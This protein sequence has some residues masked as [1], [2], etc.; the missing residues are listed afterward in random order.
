MILGIALAAIAL[1]G[2]IYAADSKTIQMSLEQER[3][4]T[5]IHDVVCTDNHILMTTPSGAYACIF[6]DH[7]FALE[8]RGFVFVS[9]SF[10]VFPTGHSGQSVARSIGGGGG[11]PP[12]I[13]MSR[14][15]NI[16]ET[17]IVEIT[18][19]NTLAVNAT[20]T[21][22][23][24][25][26]PGFI[27]GWAI[28]SGFEVV[29]PADLEYEIR[30]VNATNSAAAIHT[31]FTPLNIGESIT[32]R[33]EIR[34]ISE[35]YNYVAGFGYLDSEADISLYLD[36]EETLPY[37]E[38]RTRYPEMHPVPERTPKAKNTEMFPPLT[39][40]ERD[41]AIK[42]VPPSRELL[43]DFFEAYFSSTETDDYTVGEAM[44]FVQEVGSHLNYTLPDLKQILG[45]AGYTDKE[46]DAEWS[47]RTSTQS[48]SIDTRQSSLGSLM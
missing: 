21:E 44:D 8:D 37:Q 9:G 19:T 5:Q 32:Y 20:D 29:N 42:Y 17:A 34:A 43:S 26:W 31:A 40:E 33:F 46:I 1:S 18:Y 48:T 11:P 2:V 14:L 10:D 25:T 35:G 39:D 6:T 38:H 27:T 22:E 15:P 23:D 12:V 3:A 30:E 16:N 24:R 45:D 7:A 41:A 13:S 36:D 4:G 28:S 47:N